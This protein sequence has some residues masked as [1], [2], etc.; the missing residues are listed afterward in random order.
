MSIRKWWHAQPQ[1]NIA[2]ATGAVSNV[3]VI[4]VDGLDAEVELRRLEAKHGNLPATVEVITARGRHVYFQMPETPVRNS[5][6]KIAPGIDVRGDGGYVLA[7]P[8]IHPSGKRYEWSVDCASAF[9]AAPDWLLA[10]ITDANS[11]GA[12]PTPLSEWRVLIAS[13]VAEGSRDNTVAKVSGH[14]LRRYID[15]HV[16]LTLL[17]FHVFPTT[18]IGRRT[19][20]GST[21]SKCHVS[22]ESPQSP[23]RVKT[24]DDVKKNP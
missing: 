19:V 21:M 22:K 7:P 14:L 2:I 3:F 10:K 11:N 15:P 9:A 13:G 24:L 12:A 16:V 17:Q 23:K 4:D 18:G 1:A 5:A 8:S 20:K 6:G